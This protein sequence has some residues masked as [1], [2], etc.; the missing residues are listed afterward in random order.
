MARDGNNKRK[1]DEVELQAAVALLEQDEADE[2]GV[3]DESGLYKDRDSQ[4]EH[5]YFCCF[6][7]KSIEPGMIIM[8]RPDA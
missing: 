8:T 1:Q 6:L 7:G 5:L 3:T 4:L 2:R